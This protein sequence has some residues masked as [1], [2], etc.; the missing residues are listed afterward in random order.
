MGGRSRPSRGVPRGNLPE[1]PRVPLSRVVSDGDR[2]LEGCLACR[3]SASRPSRALCSRLRAGEGG[4]DRGLEGLFRGRQSASRPSRALCSRLRAGEGGDR[5]REGYLPRKSASRLSHP[6][7][8]AH[9][10]QARAM[11]GVGRSPEPAESCFPTRTAHVYRTL[12]AGEDGDRG[13]E[14]LFGCRQICPKYP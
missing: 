4:D 12:R 1:D 7:C 3:E 10:E 11:S 13:L 5:G 8:T 6:T 9:Y 14:G 2:G